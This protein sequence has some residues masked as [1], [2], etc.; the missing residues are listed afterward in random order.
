[1]GANLGG[2]LKRQQLAGGQFLHRAVAV[3]QA[4]VAV[5][6][7]IA[8]AGEMLEGGQDSLARQSPGHGRRAIGGFGGVGRKRPRADDGVIRVGVH[9]GVGGEIHIEAVGTQVAAN[10]LPHGTGGV[11]TLGSHGGGALIPGQV[12]GI[13]I[14]QPR[15]RA[16]LLVHR[17]KQW[18]VGGLLQGRVEGGDLFR[19]HDVFAEL[20][21]AAHG[22]LLQRVPHGVGQLGHAVRLGVVDLLLRQG[23]IQGIRPDNEQLADFFFQRQVGGGQGRFRCGRRFGRWSC[24]VSRQV[25]HH[26]ALGIHRQGHSALPRWLRPAGTQHPR[27]QNRPNKPLFHKQIPFLSLLFIVPYSQQGGKRVTSGY[28][29]V[30]VKKAPRKGSQFS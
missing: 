17:D 9:V 20:A 22:I 19:V 6:G 29:G 1:M 2:G 3:G 14:G 26:R 13:F 12:E 16:A 23:Q 30:G 11:G 24:L 8:V 25:H 21:H 4:G 27:Q 15:H 5:L 28:K 7:G 10:G 18:D